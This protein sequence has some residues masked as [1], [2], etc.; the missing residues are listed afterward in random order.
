MIDF[1]QRAIWRA[2]KAAI[3]TRPMRLLC[4]LAFA[5]ALV[6]VLGAMVFRRLDT[7]SPSHLHPSPLRI[8]FVQFEQFI[9]KASEADAQPCTDER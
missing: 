8:E 5:I 9:R 1:R 4:G 6:A 2:I 3:A 7:G